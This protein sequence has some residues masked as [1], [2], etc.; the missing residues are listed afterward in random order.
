M[1]SMVHGAER[2]HHFFVFKIITK[3]IQ[4]FALFNINFYFIPHLIFSFLLFPSILPESLKMQFEPFLKSDS[5]NIHK[6]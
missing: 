1:L 3:Q 2:S 6:A 5:F 4:H